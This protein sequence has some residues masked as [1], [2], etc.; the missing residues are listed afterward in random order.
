M[1]YTDRTIHSVSEMLTALR[2]QS[3]PKRITWFRGH[4]QRRWKL[5]PSLARRA[6]DL[7]AEG[8]IIKR[9]MQ[10]AVPYLETPLR[11][12]W[13]WMFLMQH[14]RAMTRLLDWSE[15][16]LTALFFAVSEDKHRN[17][18]GAIW[19]LDPVALNREA[20]IPDFKFESEIPG[21]G[22][23]RSLESYLPTRVDEST[24]AMGPVAIMGP[25]NTRRMAAQL[26]T[27]TVNHRD[28]TPIESIGACKHCWRW[29]VPA[30]AKRKIRKEL[31]LL[32][33]SQLT[34]FPD[35]DRVADLTKE[36]LS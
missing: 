4:G 1:R 28:H 9:F 31:A 19:C 20:K 32:G 23:D 26:G 29:I 13:E 12:E 33:Y 11:D 21:F 8:A 18:A 30:N 36:L 6:A 15:S 3:K 16:P 5:V 24:A 2:A 17:A 35:L 25:R 10:N 22:R 27:F 14:H 34:L 7:L